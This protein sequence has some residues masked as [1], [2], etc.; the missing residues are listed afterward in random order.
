MTIVGEAQAP[1]VDFHCHVDLYEDHERVIA[2]SDQLRIYTL[3]VTTT[4][5]AWRRNQEL[6]SRSRFV[7]V[8]LGLH[9]QLVAERADELA[10][11]KDLLREARYVG[12]VG[13]DGG[14]RFFRSL[15]QQK[16]IFASILRE[17][18][19]QGGKILSVHSVRSVAA[20][21]DLVE[22]HLPAD[23]RRLVLHWFTGTKAEARR[24]IDLECYFSINAEMLN[25]SRHRE[26]VAA[27]PLDRLLTE[28]DGPFTKRD[29]QATRPRDVRAL[30]SA[31][32][33][34]RQE[35]PGA[36]AAQ[37]ASNLKTLVEFGT[38]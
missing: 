35:S 12:E 2:E 13:L 20:V 37:I 36:M 10:M 32:A 30:I 16:E 15:D 7:R 8:A 18:A 34:V 4:P 19:R 28:T 29:G 38:P 21:L 5:K 17:C 26:L 31:L 1:L 25:S 22:T 33:T 24:A 11:W 14:P 27:L 6:A 23:G 9:P 3:A